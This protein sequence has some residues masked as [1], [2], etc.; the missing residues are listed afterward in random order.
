MAQQTRIDVVLAYFERFVG[1]FPTIEALAA[2]SD[3]DVT[4]A[5]SGLGYY[6]RAR[7]LRDGAR[8]VRERFGGRL[9]RG[10]EELQS[11]PGIGRYTAGAIASIAFRRPAPIVDGNV[12]RILARVFAI[13]EALGTPALMRA[14]WTRAEELV[15]LATAPRDF[16]Q[17]LMEIG[18]L[19]CT[20][21][22]PACSRCPL[23]A[24]CA[25][26]AADRV[27]E[28]PR[29]KAK[30][31][32]RAMTIPLYVV[33]NRGR[34]MMQRENGPLMRGMYHLPHGDTSLLTGKPLRVKSAEAVGSFRHTV[35]NRRIVFEVFVVRRSS[36][37][38][39]W[40]HPRDLPAIPHPSYV[41]KALRLAGI[42]K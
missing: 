36:L 8:A 2:A 25:A 6:R 35:T 3:D 29:P 32:T 23:R 18:A 7:M 1:R 28:L 38:G 16:N 31:E 24:E 41:R 42:C 26:F 39:E 30:L 4:A 12:A 34:V 13:D 11:I 19:I 33:T 37:A 10:V 40:I 17:G 5:W 14:A 9:P 22:K 20:P 15:A 21:R 27:A